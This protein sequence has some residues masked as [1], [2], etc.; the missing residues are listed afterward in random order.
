M[1]ELNNQALSMLDEKYNLLLKINARQF[2]NNWQLLSD[3]LD[4]IKQESFLH[5]DRILIVHMDTDYYDELLSFGLIVIN[6]LRMFKNKDIPLYLLLFVTNH[7]GISKEFNSLLT[8]Y[9]KKDRPTIIETLL[10]PCLLSNNFV[11]DN[12]CRIDQIEKSAI[13]MMGQQRSHR[14]AL[15]NFIADSNL[16]DQV[17]LQT[18]F[19]K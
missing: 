10:S 19:L 15:C 11:L 17:A 9:H 2:D 3:K 1:I 6:L 8:P 18:N 16:L 14:V 5:N 12:D 13:S 4:S 7:Y